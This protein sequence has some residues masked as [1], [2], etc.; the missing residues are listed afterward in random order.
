MDRT[1]NWESVLNGAE[2]DAQSDRFR[3]LVKRALAQFPSEA[4]PLTSVTKVQLRKKSQ[5]KGIVGLTTYC[6]IEMGAKRTIGEGRGKS[7][8]RITFYR[9]L[10]DRLSDEAAVGVIAHELAHAWLNE[11]KR[12]EAS[13]EREKEADELARRWGYGRFLDALAA[14]TIED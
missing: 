9:E 11:H 6:C 4:S 14:E 8:Q 10:L 7:S 12:P 2:L 5:V 1:D 13:K 3:N